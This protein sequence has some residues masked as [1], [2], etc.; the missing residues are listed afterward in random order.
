MKEAYCRQRKATIDVVAY[1]SMS[2]ADQDS[3]DLICKGCGRKAHYRSASRNKRGSTFYCTP[4]P[5]EE[6]S[7][8]RNSNSDQ[9]HDA[10]VLVNQIIKTDKKVDFP[11]DDYLE[12][13]P[14]KRGGSVNTG[15][16]SDEAREAKS[17]S[18]VK[19]PAIIVPISLSLGRAFECVQV[20]EFWT[21]DRVFIT[22]GFNGKEYR[23]RPQDLFRS[24]ADLDD[25]K[26]YAFYGTVRSAIFNS[27]ETLSIWIE[28]VRCEILVASD[29]AREILKRSNV[30]EREAPLLIGSGIMVYGFY[31]PA[32]K[33]IKVASTAHV[34][35][36]GVLEDEKPERWDLVKARRVRSEQARPSGMVVPIRN[37]EANSLPDPPPTPRAESAPTPTDEPNSASR[38]EPAPIQRA[39][40]SRVSAI[41]PAQP[42]KVSLWKQIVKYFFR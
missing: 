19:S 8:A 28:G 24:F 41:V 14:T 36:E 22:K 11:V 26:P 37:A 1:E 35:I 20:P 30:A 10:D 34:F 16:L 9:P 27:T 7:E 5:K 31:I 39:E 13:C 4:H 2:D 40:P 6:C 38:V 18:F 3:L 32:D 25:S 12:D 15:H 21:C 42:L 17:R 23:R 29:I 33:R